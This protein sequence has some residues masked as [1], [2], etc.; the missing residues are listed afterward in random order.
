MQDTDPGSLRP[1]A[2]PPAVATAAISTRPLFPRLA[3]RS[4]LGPLYELLGRDERAILVLR[5]QL[6]ADSSAVLVD[7]LDE[8][9]DDVAAIHDVLDV[10]DPSRPHVRHVEKP[11]RALLQLD[12]GTELGRP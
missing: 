12:E 4:V 2:R 9:V 11:V 7:L 1:L 8:H 5:D 10:S 6:E 3:R